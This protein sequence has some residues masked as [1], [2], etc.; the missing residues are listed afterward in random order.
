MRNGNRRACLAYL[1]GCSAVLLFLSS[2]AD[3]RHL[4][5]PDNYPR[6]LCQLVLQL[7]DVSS[8]R[9]YLERMEK[10]LGSSFGGSGYVDARHGNTGEDEQ[11]ES[12]Q[13]PAGEEDGSYSFYGPVDPLSAD[14]LHCHDGVAASEIEVM[15]RNDPYRSI[16][17]KNTVS[18]HPIGM[19]YDRYAAFNRKFKPLASGNSNMVFVAGKV[20]CLTCHDPLNKMESHLVKSDWQSALCLTCHNK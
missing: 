1:T 15:V 3:A 11:N 7:Q 12:S 17:R 9:D 19:E 18:G 8:R 5:R 13:L 20:G 14:C 10:L 2:A 16:H 4:E 6:G